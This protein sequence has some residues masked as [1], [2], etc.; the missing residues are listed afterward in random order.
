VYASSS[1]VRDL[2][3]AR[4]VG[5]NSIELLPLGIDDVAF[6]SH[7]GGPPS[8]HHCDV[9]VLADVVDTAPSAAGVGLDTHQKLWGEVAHSLL[10]RAKHGGELSADA[11]LADA[12]RRTGITL[13]AVEGR[14]SFAALAQARLVTSTA[15]QAVGETLA[16]LKMEHWGAGVPTSLP[17]A[18]EWPIGAEKRA[19][20]YVRAPW[21]VLPVAD[22]QTLRHALEGILCGA[23]VVVRRPGRDLL[24]KAGALREVYEKIPTFAHAAELPGLLKKLSVV[25][26]RCAALAEIVR[27]QHTWR[28]RLLAIRDTVATG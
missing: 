1:V 22:A 12:E 5:S 18:G 16:N 15:V 27:A 4:G 24:A 25:K 17:H 8:V 13:R 19:A 21:I 23:A 9:I 3:V 10:N 2:C 14:A 7:L 26:A 28:H 11:A 20:I 6:Q